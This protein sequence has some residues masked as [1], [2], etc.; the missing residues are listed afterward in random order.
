MTGI[1]GTTVTDEM[2]DRPAMMTVHLH[3]VAMTAEVPKTASA[4]KSGNAVVR[5]TE[6]GDD[7]KNTSVNS[8]LR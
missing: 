1:G 5:R 6:S 2:I 7:R 8:E 4:T 3:A